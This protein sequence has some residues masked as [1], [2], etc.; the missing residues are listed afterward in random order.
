MLTSAELGHFVEIGASVKENPDYSHAVTTPIRVE[1][2]ALEIRPVEQSAVALLSRMERYVETLRSWTERVGATEAVWWEVCDGANGQEY[3]YPEKATVGDPAMLNLREECQRLV[4]SRSANANNS[5]LS[6]GMIRRKAV[7][8]RH[9]EST[10]L[11][12]FI[13]RNEVEI[14]QLFEQLII[15]GI[16]SQNTDPL[17]REG[18][19]NRLFQ[20]VARQQHAISLTMQF[21]QTICEKDT[22]VIEMGKTSQVKPG[23]T[24]G[25]K[26]HHAKGIPDYMIVAGYM[27]PT[28]LKTMRLA[29]RFLKVV[30][31]DNRTN[32]KVVASAQYTVFMSSQLGTGYNA[33][34]T[35]KELYSGNL[36]LLNNMPTES[37]VEIIALLRN[38]HMIQGTRLDKVM[39]FGDKFI[40]LLGLLAEC[41]GESLPVNQSRIF[42]YFIKDAMDMF[43]SVERRGLEIWLNY[44]SINI[45]VADYIENYTRIVDQDGAQT[46][47]EHLFT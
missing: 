3:L 34:D 47:A 7:V 22:C 15:E 46:E 11:F 8:M 41:N 5:V 14:K 40:N 37:I 29:W 45:N 2:D 42:T 31:K 10:Q 28:M 39:G 1:K 35:Y 43:C 18:P 6:E 12:R 33:V 36:G 44:K 19:P 17:T 16:D 38:E 27:G 9:V 20:D 32:E 23:Q 4:E 24:G 13:I 21:L 26:S 30:V 25:G